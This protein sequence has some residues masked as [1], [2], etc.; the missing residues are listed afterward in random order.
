MYNSFIEYRCQNKY[1][2]I[3]PVKQHRINGKQTL[4]CPDLIMINKLLNFMSS[5]K[6]EKKELKYQMFYYLI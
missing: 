1:I 4:M 3:R 2:W 6:N 5:N